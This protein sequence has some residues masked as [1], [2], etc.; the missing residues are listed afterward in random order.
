MAVWGPKSPARN[1]SWPGRS[2]KRPHETGDCP[3]EAEMARTG[4]EIVRTE[5]QSS[6]RTEKQAMWS[7]KCPHGS[8]NRPHRLISWLRGAIFTRTESTAGGM[9]MNWPARNPAGRP[10]GL[11]SRMPRLWALDIGH[12]W[13]FSTH[14]A[15]T[16]LGGRLQPA[17]Q[18]AGTGSRRA[19]AFGAGAGLAGSR[20][21]A[22]SRRDGRAGDDFF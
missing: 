20:P 2:R 3:H 5:R 15:G 17:A 6:A 1:E 10:R 16:H 11:I 22:V 18:L 4:R 12:F 13:L 9:E 7:E 14:G 19:A 21:D 8:E